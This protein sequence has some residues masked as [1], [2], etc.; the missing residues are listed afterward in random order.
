MDPPDRSSPPQRAGVR[1]C[2]PYPLRRAAPIYYIR[3]ERL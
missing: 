1:A 2:A 3:I